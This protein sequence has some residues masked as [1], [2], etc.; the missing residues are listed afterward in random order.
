LVQSFLSDLKLAV[1]QIRTAPGFAATAVLMLAFGIGA[2]TAIFSVVYGVLLRPLPFPHA[3]RLVVVGDRV[4]GEDQGPV[5]AHDVVLYTRNTQTFSALG[6]YGEESLALGG[7]GD[8]VQVNAGRM[9]AGVFQALGVAPV[10][11][12]VFTAEEDTQK[13]PVAV[14]SY[15]TWQ[16]R[17]GGK[18]DVVGRKILLDRRPYEVIGVMPR[19]FEFPVAAGRE[20]R[21]ELW[22]PMSFTAEELAP[23]ATWTL[24]MVGRLKPGVTL[25]QARG[26]AERVAEEIDRSLPPHLSGF[27]IHAAVYPLQAIT[28]AHAKPLLRMLMLAVIVVLLIACANL[29]GLLLVRGIRRQ[30]EIAVRLALGASGRALIRQAVLESTTLSV[31]GGVLGIGLAGLALWLGR[32]LLPNTLPRLNAITLNW[33]VVIFALLLAALTG[34]LCGLAPG[35]AALRTNVNESLKE[36]GRTGT[37]GASQARLRSI[38]VVAEIAVALILLTASLLLLRSFAKMDAVDLGFEPEHVT[39]ANYSLPQDEYGTEGQIK[40]FHEELLRRLE[41]VPGVESA[42]WTNGLPTENYF[43]VGVF[44]PDGSDISQSPDHP[45]GASVVVAGDYFRAMGIPLLRGRYFTPADDGE[46]PLVTIVN[47]ELAERYWPGQNPV[48]KRIRFGTPQMNT[49]WMTV[50][51]EIE[52]AKMSSPDADARAQFYQPLSQQEKS[53]GPYGSP[54]DRNGNTGYIAVRSML[55]APQVEHAMEA[56]V[57][58]MDPQLPLNDVRTMDE[59]V[60]GSEAP[61]R[62]NTIVI[63]S[64]ALAA[65]LLAL[66]GIY[67]VIAFSVASRVEEMAIRMALGAQRGGIVRLVLRAGLKLAAIGCVLGLGGAAAAAG[68][69]RSF[70]FGVSPFDP[71]AMGVGA[72]LIFLLALLGSALP[73]R[74]AASVDPS[75]A[76]RGL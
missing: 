42:G 16:R 4:R 27:H 11:G 32:N 53:F 60:S 31:S 39:T 10:L 58:S 57:R 3:D 55:P 36:G 24:D 44:L 73:A 66:L 35:V 69:L 13:A 56:T 8:P 48:G 33:A 19:D 2:T 61:R 22:V 43:Y 47:H 62:F 29:A 50:V 70:L 45:T 28:V 46:A 51:G 34:L 17:F 21:M 15:G 18:R 64:F 9:T 38:L 7:T 67:S 75:K 23:D 76:L 54:A 65:V 59:V 20:N 6:G 68:L 25:A 30:R 72:A 52:D 74:R 49:P 63:S 12:R 40:A 71:L 26:D 37:T 41:Q 5:T 14:L 1:R